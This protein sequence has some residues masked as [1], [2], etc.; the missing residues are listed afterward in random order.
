MSL[1]AFD[2]IYYTFTYYNQSTDYTKYGPPAQHAGYSY[3]IGS[4]TTM[5]ENQ[6]TAQIAV[7]HNIF[8]QM[9]PYTCT[10]VM[11]L[12]GAGGIDPKVSRLGGAIQL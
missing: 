7:R 1:H 9:A 5:Q 6:P 8:P 2:L 11:N 10:Y 12:F 4:G 3:T